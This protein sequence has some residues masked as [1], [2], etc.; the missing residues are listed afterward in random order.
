MRRVE[1]MRKQVEG[2][3]PFDLAVKVG[4]D[5]SNVAAEFPNDLT[6]GA[7]GRGKRVGISN[8]GDGLELVFAFRDG[9]EDRHA[10]GTKR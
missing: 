3:F 6:T 10:L 9:F 7:A 2:A 4:H 5:H 1:G 8:N